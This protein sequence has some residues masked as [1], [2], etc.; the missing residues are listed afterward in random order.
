QSVMF[1]Y[2][3][4]L[5]PYDNWLNRTFIVWVTCIALMVVV[6]LLTKPP[7]P[8]K[9]AAIIWTRQ[10]AKLPPEERHRNRGV[11]N[12]FLWWAIMA[13]LILSG[14]AYVTWFQFWG[15]EKWRR[16]A[17]FPGKL[18]NPEIQYQIVKAR[19]DENRN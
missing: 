6:S 4:W 9:I 19:I 10:V 17:E 12:L 2:V 18:Q 14:Y 13:G 16:A 8:G 15:S 11:R 1:K 7:D 3:P 5:V